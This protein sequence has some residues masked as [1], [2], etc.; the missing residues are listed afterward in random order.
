M[1]KN[2]NYK[3]KKMLFIVCFFLTNYDKLSWQLTEQMALD[4]PSWC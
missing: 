1:I 2:L 3:H 4:C